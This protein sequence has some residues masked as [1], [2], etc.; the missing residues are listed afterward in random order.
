MRL[1]G[2]AEEP[3]RPGAWR[4]GTSPTRWRRGGRYHPAV[5]ASRAENIASQVPAAPGPARRVEVARRSGR[6][7]GDATVSRR[8][9]VGWP[10][11]GGAAR[12]EGRAAVP[13]AA[14]IDATQGAVAPHRRQLCSGDVGDSPR[15]RP[16]PLKPRLTGV[17]CWPVGA[18]APRTALRACCRSASGRGRRGS[19][20]Q[21]FR[22]EREARGERQRCAPS[23][24]P[25]SSALVG[26]RPPPRPA[27]SPAGRQERD[28][29][30]PACA[31][32]PPQSR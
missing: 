14:A 21:S 20:P 30:T 3:P 31:R 8:G 25:A 13:P 17:A 11:L 28:D 6:A 15:P 16:R 23:R 18:P 2:H 10:T 26:D 1:C 32:L 29:G 27:A 5:L 9:R 7:L 24:G 4:V 22:E 19:R 12:A